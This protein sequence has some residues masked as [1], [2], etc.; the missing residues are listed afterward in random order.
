M[1]AQVPV[2]TLRAQIDAVLGDIGADVVKTGMLLSAEV[3][4][5]HARQLIASKSLSSCML[6]S[7]PARSRVPGSALASVI[8]WSL[9]TVEDS[10]SA[11]G[12]VQQAP[13]GSGRMGSLS[14]ALNAKRANPMSATPPGAHW[15][16]ILLLRIPLCVKWMVPGAAPCQAV[17]AVA[18]RVRAH[19]CACLVVDPVLVSTSGHALGDSG[20]AHALVARCLCGPALTA[21]PLF[22][23]VP[24]GVRISRASALH[25]DT[26]ASSSQVPR[27]K[28]ILTWTSPDFPQPCRLLC[29]AVYTA[30]LPRS[31]CCV[32]LS[33]QQGRDRLCS[34]CMLDDRERNFSQPV[35]AGD[36]RDA[37]PAGG[38][39]TAG[40]A[41]Y[42]GR[43][44]HAGRRA[45]PARAGA[46]IRPRQGRPPADR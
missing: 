43:G 44:R 32:E 22:F 14:S 23:E 33:L 20:V 19:G 9:D 12:V 24:C 41:A 31:Q 27:C 46:A 10:S 28:N 35:P 42:S 5:H 21:A 36:D 2:E 34:L 6:C 15:Q 29:A 18:E 40:R 13:P 38:V 45:R 7:P 26:A 4:P 17:E 3:R 30:L 25:A 8:L 1:C 16:L 37:E 11:L 39:S